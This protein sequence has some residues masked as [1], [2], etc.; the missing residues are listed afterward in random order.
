MQG[1]LL[2]HLIDELLPPGIGGHRYA[3]T[4]PVT[5]QAAWYDLRV[6][7]EPAAEGE[8]VS[9]PSWPALQRPPGLPEPPGELR[10]GAG[11][12]PGQAA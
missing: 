9:E 2:N 8:A 7:I 6:R 3:N 5:G 1:F 12:H 4:D 10:Y 11:F